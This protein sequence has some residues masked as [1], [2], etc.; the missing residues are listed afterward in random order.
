MTVIDPSLRVRSVGLAVS[1]LGRSADFYERV[2]GLPLIAR[3]EHHAQLGP[4]AERPALVLSDI[5][6]PTPLPPSATGLYHVAWLH[7][8]RAALADSVRRVA[9]ARWPFEGASDHGV[10]EALYLSDPDGLGIELYA[11]RPRELWE[12]A[13][14]GHGVNMVTLPLD[15]EDLLA[16]SLDDPPV[17]V[18]ADTF[19]GHVHL[20]VANV[21][22]AAAFYRDALGMEE[23]AQLPSAAFLAAGGYHH[24]VG[25]N[26]WQSSGA[27]SAPDS[28][29]GLREIDFELSDAPALEALE[30]TLTGA[31]AQTRSE[32]DAAGELTVRD[33]DGQLLMFTRR[34]P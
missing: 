5:A 7:P 2:L 33:P 4:D 34:Q 19:V 17:A 18:P 15:V 25:L 29:P 13:S 22:S 27:A 23:Q 24:H 3:D 21:A 14:D 1:D 20:K 30:R 9:G 6:S 31:D 8:S 11:D 12:P 28:A 16:Q 32:L 10:S 26:S